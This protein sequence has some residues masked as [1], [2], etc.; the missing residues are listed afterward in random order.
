MAAERNGSGSMS[1]GGVLRSEQLTEMAGKIAPAVHSLAAVVRKLAP[2]IQRVYT[3]LYALVQAAQDEKL[4]EEVSIA[5]GLLLLLFGGSF[6]LVVEAVEAFRHSG[7]R[8]L[9]RA[10]KQLYAQGIAALEESEKDDQRNDRRNIQ[11]LS[12]EEYAYRKLGVVLRAVDPNIVADASSSLFSGAA[13]IV[14]TLKAKFAQAITLGASLGDIAV[15]F[16]RDQLEPR[17]KSNVP[18]EYHQWVQP[19]LVY[20]SRCIAI[21]L[22]WVFARVVVGFYC[23]SRGADLLVRNV[24]SHPLQY[25]PCRVSANLYMELS[26]F[27][28]SLRLLGHIDIACVAPVW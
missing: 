26:S 16:V 2:Y 21:S 7:R 8:G 15:D 9:V 18:T 3:G 19:T 4:E 1:S 5:V 25:V 22:A 14:A 13:A 23:A 12:N 24:R 17:I 11:E 10:V 27:V 28:C 20:T 6:A